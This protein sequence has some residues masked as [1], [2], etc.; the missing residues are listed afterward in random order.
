MVSSTSSDWASSSLASAR[1]V[2]QVDR[3]TSAR[4]SRSFSRCSDS[5]SA[6][7]T[8]SG[9]A[10]VEG[11]A[12]SSS[13]P[14]YGRCTASGTR[15]SSLPSRGC[16]PYRANTWV[17]SPSPRS[18]RTVPPAAPTISPTR[19][20]RAVANSGSGSSAYGS[21]VIC[22]NSLIAAAL[23]VPL[24][25]RSGSVTGGGPA[26]G[27]A[28]PPGPGRS[29]RNQTP[30]PVGRYVVPHRLEKWS[31]SSSPRPRAATSVMS[32]VVLRTPT[33]SSSTGPE[34]KSVT[35]TVRP[36]GSASTS[37]SSSVRACSTAFVV[38]S[39]VSSSASFSSSGSRAS[40]SMVRTTARAAAGVRRSAGRRTRRTC[41]SAPPLRV[42]P[43]SADTSVS[44]T[45][46]APGAKGPANR[47]VGR[48]RRVTRGCTP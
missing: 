22:I 8:A 47:P 43:A 11:A 45:G 12:S 44:S 6:A 27:R 19:L 15:S 28:G 38:S 10:Y 46:P 1:N 13:S 16:R 32:E 17:P 4:R 35:V 2:S 33:I 40:S 9:R 20:S 41:S 42:A 7:S 39:V 3:R 30:L 5:R 31:T 21:G 24:P 37:M 36:F 18:S 14:V 26:D 48:I 25:V 23:G 34:A 29:R